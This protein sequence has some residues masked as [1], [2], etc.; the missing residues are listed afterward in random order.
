MSTTAPPRS[1]EEAIVLRLDDYRLPRAVPVVVAPQQDP[2]EPAR[3]AATVA[4]A[5]AGTWAGQALTG[6]AAVPGA[7]A[8]GLRLLRR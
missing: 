7:L 5:V 8:A 2:A 1:P 3:I 6:A 4:R